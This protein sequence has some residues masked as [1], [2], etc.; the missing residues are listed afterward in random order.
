MARQAVVHDPHE[1]E[2]D[3]DYRC[4]HLNHPEH[5]GSDQH[6]SPCKVCGAAENAYVHGEE[7]AEKG[8]TLVQVLEASDSG[9]GSED[10]G[11][12]ATAI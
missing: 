7:A 9:T 1:Y 3:P 6:H 12:G 5:D 8:Y 11:G 2:A 10:H 4:Q